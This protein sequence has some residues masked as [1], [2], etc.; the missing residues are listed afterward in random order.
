MRA[1]MSSGGRDD[2]KLL[3]LL[4]VG[5]VLVGGI[6]LGYLAGAWLDRRWGTSPWLVVGGVVLGSL[7]GFIDLFR[8]ISRNTK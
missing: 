3:A 5:T 6:A 2:L 8:T 1:L 7:A 4:Q